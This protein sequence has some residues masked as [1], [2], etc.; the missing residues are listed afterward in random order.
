MINMKNNL[1][2]NN[3]IYELLSKLITFIDNAD[4]EVSKHILLKG[5]NTIEN[6]Q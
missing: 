2:I 4:E 1:P 5:G 3:N 6:K